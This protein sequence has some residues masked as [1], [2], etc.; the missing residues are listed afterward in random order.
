MGEYQFPLLCSVGPMIRAI[1]MCFTLFV[2][3]FAAAEDISFA[4]W[5]A[6]FTKRAIA[7]HHAPAQV[8]NLLAGVTPNEKVLERDRYQ[9]EFNRPIWAYLSSA[10]SPLRVENG[11]AAMQ[12]HQ[13]LLQRLTAETGVPSE[14]ITAIWGLESAYGKIQGNFDVVCALATLAHD[15]RRRSWAEGELMAILTLLERGAVRRSDL[16]GAWA[17]AM[18]QTQFLPSTFLQYAVD[19]D[20]DGRKDIWKSEADALA[21]TANYLRRHGW[22]KGQTWAVEV[23]LPAAFN[24]TLAED[25]PSSIEAWAARGVLP[26]NGR[27]WDEHET[28][29]SARLLLPAGAN[30]PKLLVTG[31]FRVFKR[32]N[33]STAYALGVGLLSWALSN[34]QELITPWPVG[35][36]PLSRS[37]I[38]EMQGLLKS[39]GHDPGGVDGVSGPNTR[40]ALRA[41]QQRIGLV[42]DGFASVQV[43]ENLRVSQHPRSVEPAASPGWNKA[44]IQTPP[45]ENTNKP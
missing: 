38:K 24:Y 44:N 39:N 42:P 3:P 45:N 28:G 17:G 6:N 41:Y 19:G 32:Y 30:G 13:A 1:V 23:T 12:T 20:G 21:S 5:R 33:N 18:G 15:G 16:K 9:P 7:K 2:A 14:V 29:Q 8:Q 11:K 25:T 4:Q 36:K 22:N 31:N 37:Q 34:G 43:L 10:V 26:V 35:A 40:R 27:K